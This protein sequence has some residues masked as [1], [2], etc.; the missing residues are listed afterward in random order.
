MHVARAGDAEVDDL[1]GAVPGDQDVLLRDVAVDDTQ[2]LSELVGLSMRVVQAFG[3]LLH[4]VGAQAERKGDL[5]LRRLLQQAQEIHSLDVLH[6]QEVGFAHGAEVEDLD[7]VGVIEAECDLGLVDEHRDELPRAGKRWVD[8][9][10]HQLLV[11]PLRNGGAREENLGHPPRPDS[12]DELV[13]AELLH[14]RG[15]PNSDYGSRR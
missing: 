1:H 12:S 7:D 2:R 4:G 13:F 6:G 8:L 11:Q 5:L 14:D 3:D 10:D 9:L 15:A